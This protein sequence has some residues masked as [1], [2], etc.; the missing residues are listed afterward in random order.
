MSGQVRARM[1][2]FIHS[3]V[4]K[5]WTRIS[6][7][8]PRYRSKFYMSSVSIKILGFSWRRF[9]N[10]KISAGRMEHAFFRKIF[11]RRKCVL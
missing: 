2:S 11:K 10:R 1:D 9:N 7:V 5:R 3:L 8:S 6:Y 4:S